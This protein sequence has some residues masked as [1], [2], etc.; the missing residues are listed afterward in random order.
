MGLTARTFW[1]KVGGRK[2]FNGWIA[3]FLLTVMAFPLNAP[4]AL[5]MSGILL[6]MGITQTLTTTEDVMKKKEEANSG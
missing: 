3:S 1:E 5:Y 6:A 2:N 4:Y